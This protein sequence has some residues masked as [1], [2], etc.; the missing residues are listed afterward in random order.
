MADRA[1]RGHFRG[2]PRPGRR[3]EVTYSI[4]AGNGEESKSHTAF[5]QN[6]GV[7]G[8]FIVTDEPAAPGSKLR[9]MVQIPPNKKM[10]LR[11]EVRWIAD[12]QRDG[13]HGMGVKFHDLDVGQLLELNEYFT[14]L[15]ATVDLD[16]A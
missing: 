15:T 6:I 3:V 9:V 10:D 1:G 2:S 11:A 7:G 12:S 8:A 13:V 4:V 5:T 16:D 14:S